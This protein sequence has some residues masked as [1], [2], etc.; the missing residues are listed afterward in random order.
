ML[1]LVTVRQ[2]EKDVALAVK[3][4][5]NMDK[6]KA[7]ITNLVNQEPL[8]PTYKD[9]LLAGNYTNHREL[10][11][12]PDWLLIYKIDEI[13]LILIRTGSHSDLFK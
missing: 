3:R 2:F 5:K 7:V 13:E 10:H 9:H 8:S 6:L 4:G 1:K 11:L 12:E